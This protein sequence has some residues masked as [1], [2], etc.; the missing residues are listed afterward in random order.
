MQMVSPASVE[1]IHA[2]YM[3]DDGHRDTQA[4]AQRKG[5]TSRVMKQIPNPG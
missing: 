1:S 3:N 4:P 5:A 2:D